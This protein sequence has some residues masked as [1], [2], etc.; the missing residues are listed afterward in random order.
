M[1][2]TSSCGSTWGPVGH[3]LMHRFSTAANWKEE[4]K[5]EPWDYHHLNHLDL[6]G[7][8]GGGRFTLLLGNDAFALMPWLVKPNS[9]RQLTR[10]ERI[11]NYRISRGRRVVENS[12]GILVKRFRVLLTTIEQRPKVVRDLVLTYVVL[13]NMLISH[14]GEQSDHPIRLTTYKHHRGT[15]GNRDIMRT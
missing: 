6:G 15:R 8:G 7:G 1:Q 5:T 10:E 14:Q 12:F 4:L 3:H 11:A 2:I 9:R 13:H